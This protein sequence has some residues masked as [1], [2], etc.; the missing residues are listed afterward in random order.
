MSVM[1]CKYGHSNEGRSL[2]SNQKLKSKRE[3]VTERKV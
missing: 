1:V 3:T 2:Y